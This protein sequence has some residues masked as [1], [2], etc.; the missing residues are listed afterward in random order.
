M[1]RKN[2]KTCIEGS[3]ALLFILFVVTLAGVSLWGL[4][5]IVS[6]L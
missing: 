3:C 5:K 2:I 4:I 6:K 1:E